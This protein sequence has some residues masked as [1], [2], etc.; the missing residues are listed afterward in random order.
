MKRILLLVVAFSMAISMNAQVFSDDFQSENIDGWTTISPNYAVNATN[1]HLGDHESNYYVRASCYWDDVN[2][3]TDQW[4]ISPAIDAS[5]AS[6]LS[7]TFDNEKNYQPYQDLELYA[8]TD[9]T[10]SASFD[11]DNWTKITISGLATD[12][13]WVWVAASADLSSYAGEST[14]YIAFKYVS[15]DSEGGVWDI[16]NVEVSA[17]SSINSVGES[18]FSLYPNPT[19]N[20]IFF[21][22]EGNNNNVQI[23]NTVGQVVLEASNAGNSMNVSSLQQGV[24]SVIIK[25]DNG[26]FIKKFVKK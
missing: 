16:D 15:T 18:I 8:Y 13:D 4:I 11:E 19:A 6:T 12:D 1:W 5:S 20:V 14:L 10:D 2:H 9:F 23:I 7:L 3:A 25:N 21:N 26:R 17:S 24:Y 22:V